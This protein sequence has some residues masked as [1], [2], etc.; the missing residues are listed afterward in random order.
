LNQDF[1]EDEIMRL[2]SRS[3]IESNFMSTIK[4][5]DFLKHRSQIINSM[6]KKDHNQL[7]LGLLND[8]FDQFWQV[9]RRLMERS[10]G[11]LFRSLPIRFYKSSDNHYQ[12]LAIKPV[13]ESGRILQFR[14]LLTNILPEVD[15]QE[16][17]DQKTRWRFVIHGIEP[18][19][20]TPLQWLSE[21]LS[22]PDNFLHICL[23]EHA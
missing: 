10:N 15:Q 21:H 9:N 13:D 6:Q 7:W 19:L 14:D 11:E 18:P 17:D 2:N 1:P 4:E 23:L 8:K 12:Q 22:Y 3:L 5:A 20:D 16:L